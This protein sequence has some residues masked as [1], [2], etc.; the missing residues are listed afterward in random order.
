[1]GSTIKNFCHTLLFLIVI[2]DAKVIRLYL[3]TKSI[4][5]KYKILNWF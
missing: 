1:V 3:Q 5:K 4:L 2:N